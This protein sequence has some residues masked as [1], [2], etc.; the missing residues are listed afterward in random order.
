[1][2]L[3]SVPSDGSILGFTYAYAIV[4]G[5]MLT[6]MNRSWV[7]GAVLCGILGCAPNMYLKQGDHAAATGDWKNAEKQ[8]RIAMQQEPGEKKIQQK[9]AQAKAEAIRQAI[10]ISQ[11]C[12]VEKDHRC[13]ERESTYVLNLDPGN[14]DVAKMR[15][16]GRRVAALYAIDEA[17]VLAR[18]NKFVEALTKLKKSSAFDDPEVQQKALSTRA[19]ITASA[20]SHARGQVT[21]AEG[22]ESIAAFPLLQSA[23]QTLDLLGDVPEAAAMLTQMTPRF[24][25][26][27]LEYARIKSEAG[28]K[29]ML[30][31][32]WAAAARA[33]SA[34][35]AADHQL[36][37][38]AAM[39][40]ALNEASKMAAR[41]DY[42]R[43]TDELMGAKQKGPELQEMLEAIRPQSYRISLDAVMVQ[44]NR[45]G[46]KE[47]WVG[48]PDGSFGTLLAL[49]ASMTGYGVIVAAKIKRTVDT[50]EQVNHN[51]RP[52]IRPLLRLPDGRSLT[53]K[54]KRSLFASFGSSF[55]VMSNQYDRR[56]IELQVFHDLNGKKEL[57]GTTVFRIGDLVAQKE[58]KVD[59]AKSL[60]VRGVIFSV[61]KTSEPLGRLSG[62]K[63]INPNNLAPKPSVATAGSVPYKVASIEVAL[64]NAFSG[65]DDFSA[66]DPYVL[67]R[68]GGEPVVKTP[69]EED[70]YN[71]SWTPDAI[72]FL[73][74][75]EDLA[76]EVKD[77]DAASANDVLLTGV[78]SH[79][80]IQTGTAVVRLQDGSFVKV[81][82]NTV[83]RGPE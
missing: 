49:G 60:G 11:R 40:R 69:K 2:H 19:N 71:T 51:N 8:Y 44:P 55:V 39:V 20:I 35:A 25:A 74:P 21:G 16:E 68:Q 72:V 23:K 52:N 67:L 58:V 17:I 14:A 5:G 56:E 34:A 54:P 3:V 36:H 73:K 48:R 33:L 41:G 42:Q 78:L 81:I 29:A 37:A 65:A 61:S 24:Q 4:S 27:S 83:A 79:A 46:T 15:I 18:S 32:N 43:A 22:L 63:P 9:Y 6:T 31:K 7:I 30:E 82:F 64:S 26:V 45:P 77:H 59:P 38:R 62:W 66:P 13:V 76:L 50:L 70:D 47:P 1:M 28:E 57:V 53:T 75:G 80:Q 10:G 12:L